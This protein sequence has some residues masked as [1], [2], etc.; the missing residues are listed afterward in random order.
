[1]ATG[2]DS[3]TA[4]EDALECFP[5]TLGWHVHPEV[6]SSVLFSGIDVNIEISGHPS[7]P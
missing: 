6:R 3:D 4:D 7:Q 5:L 2:D 1:M